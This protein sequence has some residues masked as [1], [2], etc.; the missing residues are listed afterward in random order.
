MTNLEL[1][2]TAAGQSGTICERQ[3][4]GLDAHLVQGCH[5]HEL[6]TVVRRRI[7]GRDGLC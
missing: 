4:F 2:E 7:A 1:R 3:D 5:Q 6:D